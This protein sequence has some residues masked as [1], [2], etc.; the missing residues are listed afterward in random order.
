MKKIR[1]SR[2]S[3]PA[4]LPPWIESASLFYHSPLFHK[5]EI[6]I[7]GSRGNSLQKL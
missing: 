2:E 5:G 4:F 3:I 6:K 1:G 7:I